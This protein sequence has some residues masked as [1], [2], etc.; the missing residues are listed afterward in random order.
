MFDK[1]ED[2]YVISETGTIAKNKN[3][4]DVIYNNEVYCTCVTYEQAYYVRQELEKCNWDKNRLPNILDNYPYYYTLLME[5]YR[6]IT[7]YKTPSVSKWAVTIP[8]R[9]SDNHKIQQ[10]R[11]SNLE[12]ALFER[13]F[14]L[15]HDWD[16]ELLV[17][18]INDNENPYYDV[19]LPPYPQRKI[20]NIRSRERHTEELTKVINCILED[21]HYTQKEICK[22]LDLNEMSL[23]NWLKNYDTDWLSFRKMVLSGENPFDNL[24]LKRHIYTPDLSV[25]GG[26]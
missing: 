5:F 8:A 25:H 1:F 24:V 22:R 11:C 10:V 3:Q 2:L 4:Y 19:N 18:Q 21:E 17:E 7:T 15:A 13:D 23:R 12:D 16:Y 9:K 6:H 14:L 26:D 20:K